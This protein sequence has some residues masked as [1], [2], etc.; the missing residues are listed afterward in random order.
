MIRAE[1]KPVMFTTA[2]VLVL[3]LAFSALAVAAGWQAQERACVCHP[4]PPATH[5]VRDGDTLWSIAR[6][7]YPRDRYDTRHV[8]EV[9]RSAN[10]D[11]DPGR[12]QQGSTIVLPRFEDL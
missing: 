9:I 7:H 8:V 3:I 1:R 11:V 5:V 12:L 10:P 2:E 4:Q 6:Q